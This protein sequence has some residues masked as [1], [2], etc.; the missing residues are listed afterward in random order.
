VNYSIDILKKQFD[1]GETFKY[2]FFWGYTPSK[3]G[4]V[5]K[6]CF[7]QWWLSDF[8]VDGEVYKTAA[9]W[10]MAEKA[11]LFDNEDIRLKILKASHPNEVKS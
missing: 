2:I 9:H 10:M 4:S 6:T 5:Q 11:R 8:T 7:S 3:D 1:A